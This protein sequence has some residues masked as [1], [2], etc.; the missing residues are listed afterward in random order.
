[1]RFLALGALMVAIASANPLT[2]TITG[3][4]SGSLG[5]TR[6]TSA[7]FKFTLTT[8]TSQLV[9]PPC[10][11][12]DTDTPSGTPTTFSITGVGSGTLTDNQVVFV[13]PS[14]TAGLAHFNDGDMLDL[15]NDA[16]SG[17]A[18]ATSKGP[19]TGQPFIGQ[20][21]IF[22]TSMGPLSFTSAS[23]ITFT[24]LVG[25]APVGPTVTSVTD[26]F[27]I[28]KNLTAGMPIII[29][30]TNFG[31]DPKNPPSI[32]VSGETASF[33]LLPPGG[34]QVFAFLP[35]DLTPGATTLTVTA[36]GV[37][38][39]PF[40][41]PI[42]AFAPVLA[43]PGGSIKSSFN[44]TNNNPITTASP[45]VANMQVYASALGL[46]PTNP[47]V[48]PNTNTTAPA[49]TTTPVQVMVGNKMVM[50]DYAG[51]FVGSFSGF[52]QVLFKVPPDAPVGPQPVTISV[53]GVTSNIATLD[54][55]PPIPV[56]DAIVNGATFQAGKV[57]ANSFVSLFGLNFGTQNT[58]SNIFP[59]TSFNG[60][61][62]IVD[63]S[64][65]PLYFVVGTGGQINIVLP[66]EL[67]ESGTAHVQVMNTQGTS[68]VFDLP[69]APTSVGIF[70]IGDPSKPTRMN[71][72]VLFSNTAWKVMPLSMAMALGFPSCESITTASVC[73]K[74]AKVG[75]QVQIYLTGLGKATP[76]GDPNGKVLPTGSL[77]PGD[78]SVLYKTVAMPTVTVGGVPAVVSFSGIAPGNAGQY[79]INLAI[80]SGVKAGD[81]VPVVV[82]MPDGSTDTVTIAIQDS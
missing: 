9:N 53:G 56:I 21:P 39:A 64:P 66:S 80:P 78:G 35:D 15:D 13:D 23:T 25:A 48:P 74:P 60:V 32:K 27:G 37:E 50:P 29:T 75:D 79:Q 31:T 47:V 3:A 19:V 44:D 55:G 36:G 22:G 14:G 6:F 33:W 45:A 12:G 20:N 77:A 81:D 5:N 57:A 30:G 51:L 18:M 59:A 42:V 41:V 69:L 82:S 2:I 7:S 28:G 1:M 73:G 24:F 40:S 72:A 62:V 70:R 67:P 54:V 52:Y 11:P 68:A 46:G 76:N 16:F 71:G 38:S 4:G 63:D 49:P 10:C 26:E 17:Y 34:T 65:V 58:Q 8:D 43:V 61:S